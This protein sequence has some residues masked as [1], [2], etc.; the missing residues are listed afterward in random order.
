[1]DNRRSDGEN[2]EAGESRGEQWTSVSGRPAYHPS[3]LEWVLWAF[4]V[5]GLG[6][7]AS[8]FAEGQTALGVGAIAVGVACAAVALLVARKRRR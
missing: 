6:T 2:A 5:V 1:M 7:G 8:G 3:T 4:A